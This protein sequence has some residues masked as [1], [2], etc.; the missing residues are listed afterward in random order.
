MK[1]RYILLLAAV[2]LGGTLFAQEPNP[3]VTFSMKAATVDKV[4]EALAKQTGV[5]I[6]AS[7]AISR[8]VVLI[9]VTDVPLE[10]LLAKLADVVSGEW[11]L[12]SEIGRASW[13]ERAVYNE[14]RPDGT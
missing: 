11:R 7:P 6:A 5:K 14:C 12:S 3:R 9:S 8:E 10:T 2:T 4:V 1:L 13:R